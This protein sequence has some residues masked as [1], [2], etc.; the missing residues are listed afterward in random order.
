M[1]GT[2]VI[3]LDAELCWGFHDQPTMPADRVEAPREAWQFLHS[4]FATHEIPATWAVVGHL[5]LDGCDG[6]HADHPTDEK[7]F[8]RDPGGKATADS[9]WFAPE[10]IAD[11]R[12]SDV[13]HE[14]GL[15]GFSHVEFGANETSREIAVAELQESVAAAAAVGINPTSFVYPRNNIGYRELLASVD[16]SCYRGRQPK[17]WYGS[18]AVPNAVGKLA[19]YTVG[20]SPP[21]VRP[22]ADAN[23]VVNLPASLFL[24]SF[25]G[26]PRRLLERVGRDPVVRQVEA[27]LDALRTQPDG[28]LHCWLHPNNITSQ[29]DR[30]RMRAIA[31]L[32]A[33]Y[34]EQHGIAIETMGTVAD[35]IE[36]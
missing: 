30:N 2:V 8:A 25:E 11:I 28:V 10:L 18:T 3:S 32:I 1:S 15:H 6:T 9:C 36:Y 23:G 27:G 34:R 21:I 31:T 22:T 14:I 4:L 16:I 19:T 13:D 33:D 12:E 20:L 7:W 24:F 5:F 26:T 29:Q 35:R 17:R